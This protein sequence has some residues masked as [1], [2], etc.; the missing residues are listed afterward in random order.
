MSYFV[1]LLEWFDK[2]ARFFTVSWPAIVVYGSIVEILGFLRKNG[3]TFTD[4]M[5]SILP[6][7]P[8]WLRYSIVG[9]ICLVLFWHFAIQKGNYH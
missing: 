2:Y 6:E 9:A 7:N 1:R 8:H 4:F 5:R 3:T